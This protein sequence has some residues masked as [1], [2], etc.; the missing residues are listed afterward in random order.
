[1]GLEPIR[2]GHT[3]LKRACLP[4]PALAQIQRILLYIRYGCLSTVNLDFFEKALINS[5]TYLLAGNFK[6]TAHIF[7][8]DIILEVY[9]RNVV[10]RNIIKAETSQSVVVDIPCG[11]T[12]YVNNIR[13]KDS[14]VGYKIGAYKGC[15]VILSLYHFPLG[16]IVSRV[17]QVAD[18]TCKSCTA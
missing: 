2:R 18:L 4:I 11:V 13:V 1:M 16:C 12:S 7:L 9:L 14:N 5:E 8:F 3:H 15:D 6:K 10:L 17:R